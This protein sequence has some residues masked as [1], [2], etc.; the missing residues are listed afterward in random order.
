MSPTSIA[1]PKQSKKDDA[2]P[3]S[4]V[5]RELCNWHVEHRSHLARINAD[6]AVTD[7]KGMSSSPYHVAGG[8]NTP[9]WSRWG[10]HSETGVWEDI[11]TCSLWA[12]KQTTKD[13]RSATVPH[14]Q[15]WEWLLL[16]LL[17]LIGVCCARCDRGCQAGLSRL[18]ASSVQLSATSRWW[19][20]MCRLVSQQVVYLSTNT[21]AI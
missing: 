5:I 7:V 3:N 1:R 12:K 10:K 17:Q 15:P 19:A 2:Q 13:R 9:A 18:R 4:T 8:D 14:S 21:S 6:S 16:L 20:G 11:A